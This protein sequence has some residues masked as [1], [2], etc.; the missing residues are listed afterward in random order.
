MTPPQQKVDLPE[1]CTGEGA[2][3]VQKGKRTDPKL[4]K[5]HGKTLD[6]RLKKVTSHDGADLVAK[7]GGEDRPIETA[8][9]GDTIGLDGWTI[10]LTSVCDG[11]IEFDLI[12]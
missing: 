11:Q 1:A 5:R 9:V 7:I 8:H 10:S 4:P 3:L 2:Y 6:V 12:D